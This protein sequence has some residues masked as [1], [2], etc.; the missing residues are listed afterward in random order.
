MHDLEGRVSL[1]DF[2]ES[3][4]RLGYAASD[5]MLMPSRFEPCGLPQMVSTLY[6]TLP[7]VHATGGLKDTISHLDVARNEGNGFAFEFYDTKGFRWAI[8]QAMQ[9]Y[10]RDPKQREAQIARI[11]KDGQERFNHEATAKEYFDIY[12]KMLR[13]PLTG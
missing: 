8:D 12:E 4:S 1:T 3:L 7:I 9:F 6:G 10:R 11:M 13:R 2:D 5:F